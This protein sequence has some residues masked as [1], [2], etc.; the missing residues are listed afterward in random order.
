MIAYK[1]RVKIADLKKIIKLPSDI[2]STDVE[3][4][5]LSEKNKRTTVPV[6]KKKKLGGILNK[7]SNSLLIDNEKEIAWHKIIEEKHGIL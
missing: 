5:I 7:Y 4:I 6:K 1:T 2:N 3:L